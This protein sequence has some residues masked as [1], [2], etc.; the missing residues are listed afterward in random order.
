MYCAIKLWFFCVCSVSII[1]N[2]ALAQPATRGAAAAPSATIEGRIVAPGGKAISDATIKVYSVTDEDSPPW[3]MAPI[4][5]GKTGSAGDF[6]IALPQAKVV[7]VLARAEGF[8]LCLLR[9][10]IGI[11]DEPLLIEMPRAATVKVQVSNT[12]GAPVGDVRIVPISFI[13]GI[14]NGMF[15]YWPAEVA[16]ELAQKSDAAGIATF[17]GLPADARIQFAVEDDRYALA[18]GNIARRGAETTEPPVAP[19]PIIV[20]PAKANSIVGHLYFSDSGKPAANVDV[21]AVGSV[22]GRSSYA[23]YA[24]TD[25]EGRFMV[26]RLQPGEI[27]IFARP[28]YPLSRQYAGTN[29]LVPMQ[30]G[31]VAEVK[32]ELV[33]GAIIRGVATQNGNPVAGIHV[34]AAA[35]GANRTTFETGLRARPPEDITGVD[36]SFVLH[37]LPGRHAISAKVPDPLNM[38]PVSN[39]PVE[40]EATEANAATVDLTFEP[41]DP[42][43]VGV[44]RGIVVDEQNKPVEGATITYLIALPRRRGGMFVGGNLPR[45]NNFVQTTSDANGHFEMNVTGPSAAV[46]ARKGDLALLPSPDNSPTPRRMI[47]LDGSG[48]SSVVVDAQHREPRVVLKKAASAVKLRVVDKQGKPIQGAMVSITA[49][50][51]WGALAPR[52][53]TVDENG[54]YLFSKAFPDRE[55]TVSASAPGYAPVGREIAEPPLKIEPGKQSEK[56][57]VLKTA[58]S[59]LGGTVT[60]EQGRPLADATVVVNGSAA[61]SKSIRTNAQGEFFIEGLVE[62]ESLSVIP[63]TPTGR[64]QSVPAVGGTMDMKVVLR[65]AA[66]GTA[67]GSR[68]TTAPQ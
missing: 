63:S 65:P 10:P 51:P 61:G 48:A 39:A 3:T 64:G 26:R 24:K 34:T 15:A 19:T 43:S 33:P 18:P 37:V 12:V 55:Y 13:S 68:G 35:L 62:G 23:N 16:A 17:A 58:D 9:A 32:L 47:S 67:R 66:R 53:G 50:Y 8:G 30:S 46:F 57:I 1:G 27:R 40:V 28:T 5:D 60:D 2:C 29:V 31:P 7:V 4:A 38:F 21:M 6:R 52:W 45:N 54:A 41:G 25:A 44:V 42:P 59:F 22:D 49:R 56:I 14:R 20:E 36:G 11:G